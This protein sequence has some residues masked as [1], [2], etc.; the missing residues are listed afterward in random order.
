MDFAFT[1]EQQELRAQARSYLTERFPPERVAQLA[2]SG[3]GWDPSSWRE[4]AE[5]GWLGVS[6]PEEHGGAGLGFVEEA[7]LLEELG[8]ALYPGPYF[9][10]VGLALPALG[11]EELAQVVAGEVRWSASLDARARPRHRRPRGRPRERRRAG[12]ARA[13]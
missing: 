1:D 2:D 5:L 7:L 4:L 10:T 13:G 9:S 6:V 3:E 12:R 11:A 8:R